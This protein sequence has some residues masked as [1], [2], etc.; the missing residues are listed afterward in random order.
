MDNFAAIARYRPVHGPAYMRQLQA[1]MGHDATQQLEHIK[2][3][4]LVI[5]GD[6]DPLVPPGNGDSLAKHI[7]GAKHIVYHNVGHIPIIENPD[8]FNSDVLAFLES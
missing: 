4:T 6:A 7:P 5:H 1:A 2:A 8:Q 3:P